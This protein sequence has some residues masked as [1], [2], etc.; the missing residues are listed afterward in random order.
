MRVLSYAL[1]NFRNITLAVL[2]GFMLGSLNKVWPW[3]E[4]IETMADGHIKNLNLIFYH[5]A[6][7]GS[8]NFSSYWFFQCVFFGETFYEGK[9]VDPLTVYKKRGDNRQQLNLHIGYHLFC[10]TVINK[11]YHC[12]QTATLHLLARM[13]FVFFR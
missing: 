3:K 11:V 7:M 6:S 1:K 2:T 10:N 13:F 9:P 12:N 5:P 4:K 8:C